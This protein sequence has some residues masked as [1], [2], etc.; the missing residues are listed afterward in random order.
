[1]NIRKIYLSLL[2]ILSIFIPNAEASDEL[3]DIN[4]IDQNTP[5]VLKHSLDM[6]NNSIVFD[7]EKSEVNNHR[8]YHY[9]HS[10]HSSHY[11]HRSHYSHYS[12]R[13]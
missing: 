5:I 8:L 6:Q 12:S 11:S 4:S 3:I 9:S 2:A 10:S 13:Y 1:M 7:N